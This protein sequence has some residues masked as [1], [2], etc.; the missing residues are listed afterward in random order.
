[1]PAQ[2]DENA[3]VAMYES[4]DICQY[5]RETYGPPRTRMTRKPYGP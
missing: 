4:D 2:V 5:L 1:M 3:D